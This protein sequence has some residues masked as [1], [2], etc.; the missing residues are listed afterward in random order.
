LT[1]IG[2]WSDSIR[3]K[4][5]APPPH[6]RADGKSNQLKFHRLA[7]ATNRQHAVYLLDPPCSSARKT[8]SR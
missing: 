8:R 2:G 4:S 1:G 3:K 6:Q 7:A 5:I